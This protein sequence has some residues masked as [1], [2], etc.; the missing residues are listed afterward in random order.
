MKAEVSKKLALTLRYSD[1]MA[2]HTIQLSDTQRAMFAAR[3]GELDLTQDEIDGV[4]AATIRKIENGYSDRFA[5]TTLAELA[6]GLSFTPADIRAAG[7]PQVA[8]R[9]MRLIRRRDEYVAEIIRSIE[10][11]PK[12]RLHLV[13]CPPLIVDTRG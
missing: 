8:N 6:V 2:P 10:Q 1:H 13:A 4:S 11:T 3:R 9:M 12:N 5:V 7:L